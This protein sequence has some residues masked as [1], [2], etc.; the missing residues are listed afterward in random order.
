MYKLKRER[1][2]VSRTAENI[3]RKKL[4]LKNVGDALVN[5]TLLANITKKIF[6]DTIRQFSPKWIGKF[7][8]DIY[9][10]SLKIAVEYNGIQHYKAIEKFGGE[11]KLLQQQARDEF[12][13]EKCKEYNVILLEWH[14]SIKVTEKNVYDFYSKVI[15]IKSYNKPLS[16]FD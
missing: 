3:V 8:I 9:I 6:P 11:V 16:L 14:Y 10:P 13:R 5:E 2:K 7:Q 15:N 12:V 1:E 4:G